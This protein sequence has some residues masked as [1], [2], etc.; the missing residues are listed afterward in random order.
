MRFWG[1]VGGRPISLSFYHSLLHQYTGIVLSI[2]KLFQLCLLN[3]S[4]IQSLRRLPLLLSVCCADYS[5][6]LIL[7]LLG[8]II[9]FLYP[10]LHTTTKMMFK[11]CESDHVILPVLENH[12]GL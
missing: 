4:E 9:T 12:L 6:R 1:E 11:K 7:G 3:R 8:S 2:S 10:F 5:N